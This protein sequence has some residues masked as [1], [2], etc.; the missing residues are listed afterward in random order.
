MTDF[1]FF[2]F[3]VLSSN[4]IYTTSWVV[5]CQMLQG[6]SLELSSTD[7]DSLAGLDSTP[8]LD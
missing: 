2:S 5:P 8:A 6:S 3:L 7:A 4:S 1:D